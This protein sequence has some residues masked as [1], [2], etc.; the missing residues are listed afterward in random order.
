[1]HQWAD[2]VVLAD[3][4]VLADKVVLV[5]KVVLDTM[6]REVL[7]MV[8]PICPLLRRQKALVNKL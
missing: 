8:R 6:V 4:A 5:D 2:P 3:K 7:V 1:M